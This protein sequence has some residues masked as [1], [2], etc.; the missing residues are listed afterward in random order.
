MR[1]GER[2]ILPSPLAFSG[3]LA[4][5][6]MFSWFSSAKLMRSGE[7]GNPDVDDP[8]SLH[9]GFSA[10]S[11]TFLTDWFTFRQRKQ[12]SGHIVTR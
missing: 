3:D 7:C 11:V 12:S 6:M 9:R 8:H 4:Q 5:A 2:R 10:S 1:S